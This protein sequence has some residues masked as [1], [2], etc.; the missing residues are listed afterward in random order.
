[1]LAAAALAPTGAAPAANRKVAPPPVPGQTVEGQRPWDF[2]K[3]TLYAHT[4]PEVNLPVPQTIQSVQ[5]IRAGF[6]LPA[7]R[8]RGRRI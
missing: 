6:G 3:K 8:A 1:M 7:R 2:N 5:M 4:L